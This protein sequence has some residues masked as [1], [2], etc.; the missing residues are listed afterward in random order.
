MKSTGGAPLWEGHDVTR[1][2]GEPKIVLAQTCHTTRCGDVRD[3]LPEQHL[4][5]PGLP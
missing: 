4:S 1:M 2:R 5:P 3:L